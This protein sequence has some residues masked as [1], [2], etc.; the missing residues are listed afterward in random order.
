MANDTAPVNN[1]AIIAIV[2]LATVA[3]IGLLYFL[4]PS[5]DAVRTTPGI[6]APASPAAGSSTNGSNSTYNTPSSANPRQ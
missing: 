1:T 3:I 5:T 6:E 4:K 2:V